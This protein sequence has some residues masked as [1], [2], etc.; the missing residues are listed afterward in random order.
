MNKEIKMD[1]LEHLIKWLWEYISKEYECKCCTNIIIGI[2][3]IRDSTAAFPYGNWVDFPP[4]LGR[5]NPCTFCNI[6]KA[7]GS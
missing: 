3:Y 1:L 7:M 2:Y 6:E 4:K 5:G